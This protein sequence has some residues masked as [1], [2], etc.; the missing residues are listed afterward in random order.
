[1]KPISV[2]ECE[3]LSSPRALALSS[4]LWYFDGRPSSLLLSPPSTS[5]L[6]RLFPRTFL[7]PFPPVLCSSFFLPRLLL[8]FG[9]DPLVRSRKIEYPRKLNGRRVRWTT[10][11]RKCRSGGDNHMVRV[12]LANNQTSGGGARGRGGG[13]EEEEVQFIG[14]FRRAS[15]KKDQAA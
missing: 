6:S 8:T 5:Y 10:T 1:M 15:G 13:G 3:R 2:K 14:E 12:N 11:A 7:I 9:R 4:V